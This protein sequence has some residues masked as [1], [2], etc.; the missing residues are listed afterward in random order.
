MREH[1][2]SVP[3]P[4]P[5]QSSHSSSAPDTG[6]ARLRPLARGA[7]QAAVQCLGSDDYLRHHTL[8]KQLL[9]WS[10]SFRPNLLYTQLASI[11]VMRLTFQL[12]YALRVPIAVHMMDDWP[13]VIYGHGLLRRQLRTRTDVG[14]RT[15][16]DSATGRLA[17]SDQMAIEYT[18]R[19]G[20]HWDVFHNPV[21]LRRWSNTQRSSWHLGDV[22]RLVYSGRIGPGIEASLF[23]VSRAVAALQGQERQ[24]TFDIHSPHFDTADD[25]R[26]SGF[27]GVA[28]HGAI[29]DSA[30]PATLA[31]ADALVLPFDFHGEAAAFARLSFPTKAPAYMASGTPVLVYAPSTHA[32]TADASGRGWGYVVSD[33]SER[34]LVD[35]ISRLMRDEGLRTSLG[36]RALE[37]VEQRHNADIVRTRFATTLASAA[38][39]EP[40]S[41][42]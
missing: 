29:A 12:A 32:L 33:Q 21:D 6:F 34:A 39:P 24:L 9:S 19:Y 14:L 25:R 31:K 40:S 7:F 16:I 17:I 15:I 38:R 13:A 20:H 42:A 5:A 23:D 37:E 30:M 11:G 3:A 2:R 1:V 36:R 26:F 10:A 8:S 27:Q 35:A 4:A 18:G 28:T 22:F 41:D